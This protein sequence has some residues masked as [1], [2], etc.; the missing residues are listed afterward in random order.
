M[1]SH[2]GER[3]AQ[4]AEFR[5]QSPE[6]FGLNTPVAVLR[7]LISVLYVASTSGPTQSCRSSGVVPTV[8]LAPSQMETSRGGDQV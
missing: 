2:R 1:E 6:V 3:L 8:V 7:L 4:E 5:A